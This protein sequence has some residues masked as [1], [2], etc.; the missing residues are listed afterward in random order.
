MQIDIGHTLATGVHNHSFYIQDGG[1]LTSHIVISFLNLMT[2][3]PQPL[4]CIRGPL[5]VKQQKLV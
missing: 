1:I 2:V 4:F 3:T 5:G